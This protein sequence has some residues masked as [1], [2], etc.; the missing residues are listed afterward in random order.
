MKTPE[1]FLKD[2]GFVSAEEIDR[3]GMIATFLSEMEKGLKTINDCVAHFPIVNEVLASIGKVMETP[4]RV[5][6]LDYMIDRFFP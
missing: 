5:A 4:E 1:E 3:Q 2:N 6:V